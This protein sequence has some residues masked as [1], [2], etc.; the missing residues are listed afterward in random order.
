MIPNSQVK[1]RYLSTSIII[2]CSSLAGLY[3]IIDSEV[4]T[5]TVK[6]ALDSGFTM[7]DTAPHYGCGLGETR[8]GNAI[9]HYYAS[10][11]M[12]AATEKSQLKIWT[13][14]GRLM[15][16]K[17]TWENN[18]TNL[19]TDNGNIPGS[20]TCV[21]P[22]APTNVIPV[23]D[24]SANGA[25][26]SYEDSLQRLKLDRIHGLRIHDSETETHILTALGLNGISIQES[27][28]S[29]DDK[30]KG[31]LQELVQ[32][33]N[34]GYI[35]DVSF[36][37]NDVNI[38]LRIVKDAPLDSIDSILIAGCWNL[39]DHSSNF[40]L[41]LS[42]CKTK[43][44]KI[45][46]AGIFASGLLA[47][48]STYKYSPATTRE[49]DKR[50]Q[51]LNLCQKYDIPLPAIALKFSL[52]NEDIDAIVVG[53]KH[54]SEVRDIINWFHMD[55]PMAIFHEAQMLGLLALNVVLSH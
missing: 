20:S 1:S 37:L 55:I 13:K 41:L 38:A 14:V 31:G 27:Q 15:I 44:I 48:G 8:L 16:S 36:G 25:R 2:G 4:A 6:F 7:F 9:Q 32:L 29:H 52:I 18:S 17:D 30:D 3:N 50:Q 28:I 53:V 54:P 43:R 12:V 11:N 24:Y 34:D 35:Q 33:R 45:H 49:I 51:W 23:F 19:E 40:Q 10:T 26:K 47:G 22:E 39:L 21:F 42:E 46:N 5:E